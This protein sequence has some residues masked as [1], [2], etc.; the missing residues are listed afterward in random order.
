MLSYINLLFQRTL[1]EL[2]NCNR[3][4]IGNVGSGIDDKKSY[5]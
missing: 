4:L 1:I 3:I 5:S 2:K